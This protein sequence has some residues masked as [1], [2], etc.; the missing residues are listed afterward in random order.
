MLTQPI[1]GHVF[2]SQMMIQFGD[3]ILWCMN[4]LVLAVGGVLWQ[5][6]DRLEQE[7]C[8]DTSRPEARLMPCSTFIAGTA[9]NQ[10]D[11]FRM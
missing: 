7:G 8:D 4:L 2:F 9:R 6:P 11:C 1:K 5:N 3:L 10:N